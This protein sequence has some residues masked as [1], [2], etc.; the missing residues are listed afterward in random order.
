MTQDTAL[1]NPKESK[2]YQRSTKNIPIKSIKDK[3]LKGTLRKTERKVKE[4]VQKAIQ[5]ELLLTQDS[6]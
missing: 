6:G 2:K 4:S 5:S 1:L 3:K